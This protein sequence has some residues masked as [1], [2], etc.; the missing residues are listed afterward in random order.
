VTEDLYVEVELEA[1]RPSKM[2]LH[3]LKIH[4]TS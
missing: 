1:L 3:A 4:R 2:L